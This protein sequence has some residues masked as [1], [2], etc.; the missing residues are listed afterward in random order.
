[1]N[2]IKVFQAM[3]FQSNGFFLG[4][5]QVRQS[6][7]SCKRSHATAPQRCAFAVRVRPIYWRLTSF[8]GGLLLQCTKH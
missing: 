5:G 1:M 8:L 2:T 7:K 3:K 6:P 4:L